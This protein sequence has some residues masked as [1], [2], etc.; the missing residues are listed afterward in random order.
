MST[1]WRTSAFAVIGLDYNAVLSVAAILGIEV[2]E[3]MLRKIRA[4]EFATLRG[5][6]PEGD[7]PSEKKRSKVV[8]EYCKSCIA[9]KINK[10]CSTCDLEEIGAGK[11]ER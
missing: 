9:A 5:L 1:Q 7:N 6:Q 3:N 11:L 4:L 10:D 8:E 2:D